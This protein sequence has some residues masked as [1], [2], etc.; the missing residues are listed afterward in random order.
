M[1]AKTGLL[2]NVVVEWCD[3]VDVLPVGGDYIGKDGNPYGFTELEDAIKY[4]DAFVYNAKTLA[5]EDARRVYIIVGDR[6][7]L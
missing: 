7:M 2:Y 4:R 3:A 5:W 1:E 6:V